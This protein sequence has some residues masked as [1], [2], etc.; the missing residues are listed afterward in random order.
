MH[1]D[2]GDYAAPGEVLPPGKIRY[3]DALKSFA[4]GHPEWSFGEAEWY[5]DAYL[6]EVAEEEVVEAAERLLG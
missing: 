1:D 5:F 4:A 3:G 6:Q 2:D